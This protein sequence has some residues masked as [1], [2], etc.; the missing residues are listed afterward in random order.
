MHDGRCAEARYN[1]AD[2]FPS[3]N[4]DPS[5]AKAFGLRARRR[6]GTHGPSRPEVVVTCRDVGSSTRTKR[7]YLSA[8]EAV[9]VPPTDYADSET[10]V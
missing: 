9:A 5:T 2:W 8:G 7:R 4:Q 10:F 1:P 6:C 3:N